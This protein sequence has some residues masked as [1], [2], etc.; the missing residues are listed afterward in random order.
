MGGVDRNDQTRQ[1]YHGRL[2][3]RKYYNYIFW[4]GFEVSIANAYILY[5]RYSIATDRD[6]GIKSILDFRLKLAKELIG[7]YNSRKRP[8]RKSTVTPSNLPIHHFPR[9]FKTNEEGSQ[10]ML[11]LC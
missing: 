10:S 4:F 3:G 1:Y 7:T 11:V 2:K 9:K 6:P 8:G 5:I